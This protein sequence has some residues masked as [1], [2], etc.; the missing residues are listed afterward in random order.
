MKLYVLQCPL[1]KEFDMVTNYHVV[2]KRNGKNVYSIQLT[3]Y[4]CKQPVSLEE[5]YELHEWLKDEF[6]SK[7]VKI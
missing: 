5:A 2:D 1:C 4:A 6:E 3:C 7:S